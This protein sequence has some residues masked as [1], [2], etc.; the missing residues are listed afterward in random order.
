M[1]IIQT[2]KRSLGDEGSQIT[3][4]AFAYLV[5]HT[6]RIHQT[7]LHLCITSEVVVDIQRRVPRRRMAV[8]CSLPSAPAAKYFEMSASVSPLLLQLTWYSTTSWCD[9]LCSTVRLLT[10]KY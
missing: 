5:K 3:H 1:H 9:D 8:Q 6:A 10:L 2:F 4:D 7:S